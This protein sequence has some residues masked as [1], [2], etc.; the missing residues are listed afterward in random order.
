MPLSGSV[1]Q[2][3]VST[4]LALKNADQ[5]PTESEAPGAGPTIC[6]LTSSLG[7]AMQTSTENPA[8][9][10][11]HSSTQT[12]RSMSDGDRNT[13]HGVLLWRPRRSPAWGGLPKFLP[14]ERDGEQW[15]PDPSL[16][17]KCPRGDVL[18][19]LLLKMV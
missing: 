7:D 6:H 18:S 19:F 17:P 5:G 3:A 11:M 1:S 12:A 15:L 14:S 16:V 13:E 10:V 4:H 9:R 2:S 8:V